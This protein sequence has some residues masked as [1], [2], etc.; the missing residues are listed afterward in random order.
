MMFDYE[1]QRKRSELYRNIRR[2]FTD[3]G[4]L[5]VETPI[6]SP[7]LIPEPT[8]KCF[9]TKFSSPFDG[10]LKMYLL[11]SP[12]YF[13]KQLLASGSPDI[14]QITKCFRNSE[15][16][17]K[18]HNPEFTMLEYYTKGFDEMDTLSLTED[19]L[20]ETALE[21]TP[22]W[23]KREP[24]VM[25]VRD[26]MLE[27]AGTDLAKCQEEEAL[28]EEAA[29][30]GLSAPADESWD[31]T[32]NRIFLTYV[33]P[34]LPKGRRVYLTG[35]PYQIDCLARKEGDY[36][37]RWELYING[38]EIANTY[39]EETDKDVSAV[40]F[41]KEQ[42]KLEAER[43]ATGE[44]I[45]PADPAFPLLSIPVSSGGAMGLD[46]LLQVML[47]CGSIQPLL[48]FPLSDMIARADT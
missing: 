9:G 4:Y 14:F 42:L 26:A 34:S 25:T 16:L 18:I 32:F 7:Y 11:P 45:S 47:G 19:M 27:Y 10:E 1:A 13:M 3:R 40:Y 31:D 17:G 15:Q 8:I 6:L 39:S 38:I 30:L 35:Y 44:T 36:R 41:R 46:R 23:I 24:L 37:K 48:L 28:R 43:T 21:E 33:E 12:E 22:D 5:E 29:R 2:F 20:R